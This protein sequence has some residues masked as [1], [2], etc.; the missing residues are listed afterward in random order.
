MTAR[1]DRKLVRRAIENLIA[2]ALKYS[3]RQGEILINVVA[4]ERH[5][6][7]ESLQTLK[8]RRDVLGE[9]ADAYPGCRSPEGADPLNRA[10]RAVVRSLLGPDA[11]PDMDLDELVSRTLRAVSTQQRQLHRSYSRSRKSRSISICC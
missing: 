3:P 11:G 8:I 9:E 1:L 10:F 7:E 2:N 6:D 4:Q 5:L